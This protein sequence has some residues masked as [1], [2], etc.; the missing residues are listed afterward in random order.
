MKKYR[1]IK[2]VEEQYL[3]DHSDEISDRSDCED[4]SS[5]WSSL[6]RISIEVD[7]SFSHR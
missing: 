3:R 6:A 1:S 5:Y 4:C 2:E 7:L